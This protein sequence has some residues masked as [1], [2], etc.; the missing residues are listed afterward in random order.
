MGLLRAADLQALSTAPFTYPDV[1]ATRAGPLPAGY[2]HLERSAVVGHGAEQFERAGAALFDWA[3]Q[4]GAGFAVRATGPASQ[5]GAVVVL[6]AGFRRCGYDIP[7]RVVWAQTDRTERG[8]AYGTLPGHPE[9]GE[10]AFAVRFTDDGGVLF[11]TR[12][13]SRLASP[14]ARLGGPVSR[15]VQSAALDRYAAAIRSAAIQ[16][17]A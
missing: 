5:A 16:E 15:L 11:T 4:R 8:F 1:G 10:E 2:A 3:A 13:F 14:L 6:T 12:V 7:C 17:T 9:S